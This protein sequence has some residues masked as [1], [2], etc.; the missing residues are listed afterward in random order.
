MHNQLAL[1]LLFLKGLA[2]DWFDN[3]CDYKTVNMPTL[4]AEFK[5]YF[6][7]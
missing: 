2:L 3:L 5:A 7:P 4:L 1:F 6:C